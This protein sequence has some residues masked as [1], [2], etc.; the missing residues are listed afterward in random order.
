MAAT[1]FI[2]KANNKLTES[3]LRALDGYLSFTGETETSMRERILSLPSA[4]MQRVCNAFVTYRDTV[5]SSTV[6]AQYVNS[7]PDVRERRI[8]QYMLSNTYR[9]PDLSLVFTAMKTLDPRITFTRADAT[10]CATYFGSDG[11]MRTAAAN[12]PRFDYDPT[13]LAPKGLLIEESRANLL[14]FSDQLDNAAWTKSNATVTANA[15]TS[16]DGTVNADKLVE[17]TAT[18]V[19]HAAIR[20][21]TVTANTTYT[22]SVYLKAAERPRARFTFSTNVFSSGIT[23]NVN[24][25]TGVIANAITIGTGT[26]SGTS[27][28]YVGNG[29]WRVTLTGIIDAATTSASVTVYPDNGTTD[30]YTGDGASG[31]YVWGA[32]L[33]LGSFATSYIPTTTAAV[34]RAADVAVM[35]GTNFS[36]W[37]NATEGTMLAEIVSAPVNNLTQIAYELNDGLGAGASRIFTRRN[38]AGL[39]GTATV[40][41]SVA[42]NDISPASVIAASA[43]YKV[44]SA[45]KTNDYSISVNGSTAVTSATGTIPSTIARLYLGQNY[46]GTQMLN[47]HIRSIRYY[48]TGLTD[49]Q[50][51]GMTL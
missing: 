47:G 30:A 11:V 34:T 48:N 2:R 6:V 12:I 19:Q 31:I 27:S 28:T 3:V 43:T 21:A 41:A 29:W 16:P 37:Y 39:I 18:T 25:S 23:F 24:L 32:Q 45:F 5:A 33:E 17:N 9:T 8:L 10:S 46:I 51:Q 44:A 4:P 42:Q 35:M 7:H 15:A 20:G 14:T 36:S 49:A 13:T 40:T 1:A 26:L 50:L 22:A 38:I